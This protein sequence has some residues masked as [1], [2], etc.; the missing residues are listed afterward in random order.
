MKLYYHPVSTTC[1]P[2]M[3]LAAAEKIDIEFKL[4]DLFAGENC[5]PAFTAINPNQAVPFLED[6]D[7]R[8]AESSAILKYLADKFHAQTYPTDLRQRARV[9]E[10]MDWLNTGLYRD[11][12][13]GFIYAQA[14]PNYRYDENM[15]QSATLARSREKA[16]KWLKIF[17]EHLIGSRN[18]FVCGDQLT[19]AD[20]LG[21]SMITLGEVIRLDYS[22][23]PNVTRWLA[24]MKSLPYWASTN[25]AFYTHFVA[26]YKEAPFE[27][28]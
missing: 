23:Y 25:E 27:C 19:I 12:G 14:L 10:R 16:K 17:D 22:A 1:R 6:G 5:Q 21:A 18:R 2:I 15:V 13:Y 4:V 20:Y 24:N 28:L 11:L 3:L 26:P 9:N 8:L 7:F